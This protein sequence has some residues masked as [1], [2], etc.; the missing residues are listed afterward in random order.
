MSYFISLFWHLLYI[1]R[2]P[3]FRNTRNTTTRI[4]IPLVTPV[5]E[6]AGGIPISSLNE[7]Q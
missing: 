5:L 6:T 4:R 2:I 3:K 1:K 7:L